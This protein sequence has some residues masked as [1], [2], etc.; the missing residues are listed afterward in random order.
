MFRCSLPHGSGA[1][2][3]LLL[4]LQEEN[5]VHK[6]DFSVCPFSFIL[7]LISGILAALLEV[8]QYK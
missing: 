8:G 2:S 7:A 6:G 3:W 5:V 4:L 1:Y